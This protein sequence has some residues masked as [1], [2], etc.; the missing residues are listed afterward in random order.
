MEDWRGLNASEVRI[1]L[2]SHGAGAAALLIQFF[3]VC[4]ILGLMALKTKRKITEEGGKRKKEKGGQWIKYFPHPPF[5]AHWD[6]RWFLSC[7]R[8][9]VVR[10]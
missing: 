8:F 9:F 10:N 1:L 7:E 3:S 4:D 5:C 2:F 6:I